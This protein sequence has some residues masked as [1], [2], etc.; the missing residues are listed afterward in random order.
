[1][2]YYCFAGQDINFPYRVLDLESY[3]IL[4]GESS[5]LQP[6]VI[7]TPL[8]LSCRTIGWVGGEQRQV[9]IW[10]APP[11]V[12]L[13]VAG[14]SDFYVAPDGRTILRVDKYRK[15]VEASGKAARSHLTKLDREILVGPALVLALALRGVWCL[16]GSA[17]LYNDRLTVF[18]G[19]S[20][21]GKSTLAAYL[22]AKGDPEWRLVADD[23][24]PVTAD[25]AGVKAW[26]RFP[27]LKLSRQAQPGPGLP[28]QI[29]LD[30]ICVL[31]QAE[32]DKMPELHSLP[33][34]QA[35]QSLLRHTV[36]TR[37][38]DPAFLKGHLAFC[39]HV[40][41]LVPVYRLDYPH[42]K[43]ALPRIAELLE[44]LC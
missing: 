17:A 3:Y 15:R 6:L 24:L 31:T 40:A 22:A 32:M 11:G 4:D 5:A 38:F 34:G 7:P 16:H 35:V 43:E 39:A 29:N 19:E 13:K 21:Q 12:V 30:R 41:G 44:N 42:R 33:Q 10:S 36:G 9:D 1:M 20:G 26:P 27:Q 28:E 14:G 25:P 23:I 18:L 37:L 8:A 2:P